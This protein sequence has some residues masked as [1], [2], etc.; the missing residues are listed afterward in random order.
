MLL[1]NKNA[2]ITG[3]NRGI[4]KAILEVFAENGANVWACARKQTDE[5]ENFADELAQK[6]HVIIK[7]VYFDLTDYEQIKNS[8]KTIMSE[9][10]QIDILINNAG[11]MPTALPCAITPV[12]QMKHTFEVNF[13]SQIFLAQ[14][15]SRIMVIQKQGRIVFISSVSGFDADASFDY[16]TSKIAIIGATK[17]MANELG[18]SGITVNAVAPGMTQTDMTAAIKPKIYEE[19]IERTVLKRIAIPRE[20]ANVALFLASDLASYMTGQILRIDGGRN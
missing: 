20:I 3:C 1:K 17:Q 11:I 19:H 6:Y 12:E 18:S 4:G 9:K 10:K 7:P 8:I 14:L 15:V 16:T 13:F 2:I 5:F